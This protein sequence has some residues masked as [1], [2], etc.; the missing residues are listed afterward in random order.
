MCIRD[1]LKVATKDSLLTRGMEE[2][3]VV[4]IPIAHGDGRYFA[5]E[6]VM[7]ELQKNKSPNQKQSKIH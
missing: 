6:K 2:N 1:S 5:D 7:A 4:K 3:E